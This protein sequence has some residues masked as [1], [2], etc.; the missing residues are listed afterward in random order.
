MDEDSFVS[1]V[2]TE[3]KNG[4]S[5]S[6]KEIIERATSFDLDM[7][8]LSYLLVERGCIPPLIDDQTE[9]DFLIDLYR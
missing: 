9:T 6:E 8:M 7:N 1:E 3:L 2:V 5:I 4:K